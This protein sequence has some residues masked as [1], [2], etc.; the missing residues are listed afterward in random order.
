MA[1]AGHNS[2]FETL[3]T[4]RTKRSASEK[5]GKEKKIIIILN[6]RI[7]SCNVKRWSGRFELKIFVNVSDYLLQ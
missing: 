1:R 6:S 4:Q 3:S 2:D 5:K 7:F